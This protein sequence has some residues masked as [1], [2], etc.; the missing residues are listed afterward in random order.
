MAVFQTHLIIA[1]GALLHT[2]K[3]FPSLFSRRQPF[4][5]SNSFS[6]PRHIG[7]ARNDIIKLHPMHDRNRPDTLRWQ[8]VWWVKDLWGWWYYLVSVSLMR[9]ETETHWGGS[10]S[11]IYSAKSSRTWRAV[12]SRGSVTSYIFSSQQRYRGKKG[13][14]L[15][16][17]LFFVTAS[18]SS[19][20]IVFN[21][22][23]TVSFISTLL[24]SS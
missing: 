16:T 11:F 2:R 13:S 6:G 5:Q 7:V 20:K 10:V 12:G 24:F 22:S 18:Q 9:N 1:T 21:T 8:I 4:A 17:W 14:G 19:T 23:G 15:R 3:T